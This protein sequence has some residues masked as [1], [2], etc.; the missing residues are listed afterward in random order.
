[1]DWLGTLSINK[2]YVTQQR[3]GFERKE[4]LVLWK[5]RKEGRQI[6]GTLAQLGH[7]HPVCATQ[8]FPR[9]MLW[10]SLREHHLGHE[11]LFHSSLLF[12]SI[13]LLPQRSSLLWL[14]VVS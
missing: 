12:P 4:K 10:S 8:F 9:C 2:A 1:M 3:D 14:T 5:S 7:M 11:E 13:H 6:R